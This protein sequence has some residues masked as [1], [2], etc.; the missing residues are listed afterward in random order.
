MMTPR[1]I[2]FYEK[3]MKRCAEAAYSYLSTIIQNKHL[4]MLERGHSSSISVEV[5][6]C[7]LVT[8]EL[9]EIKNGK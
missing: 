5:W 1:V 9:Q 6:I 7:I 8:K 3:H 2:F 4:T